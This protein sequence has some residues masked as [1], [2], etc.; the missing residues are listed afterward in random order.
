MT[1][2]F[3]SSPC[4]ETCGYIGDFARRLSTDFIVKVL[5]PPD[6]RAT[7]WPTDVFQLTRSKSA[8][9]FGLDPF[10]AG[11][12]FNQLAS[13]G[14]LS[15][16][17]S[18]PSLLCFL[19]GAFAMGLRADVICSQWMIP[20]GL[21]GALLSRFLGKP[22]IVVEHSGA[23]HF[24]ARSRAGRML[25]RFIT[26]HSDRVVVVSADLRRKLAAICPHAE[27]KIDVVP[28]GITVAAPKGF[29][30]SARLDERHL[31]SKSTIASSDRTILFIG[32]LTEIKG[33]D[34]L[35]IAMK[36]I[37]NV[38]LIV[39]GDGEKRGE[40]ERLARELSIYA[41]FVGQVGA[42]E[43][44]ALLSF[45]DA[46][47]IPS[48][49][50][51]DGRTE[52]TPVVCLEALA[53]GCVLVASRVGGLAD[54]IVDGENGLLFEPGNHRMLR[55]KLMRALEDETLRQTLSENARRTAAAY[56]WSRIGTRFS[57]IIRSSLNTHG[58]P[59]NKRIESGNICG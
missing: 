57:I 52:G 16:L 54:V 4:D 51:A 20:A 3:P 53:A 5:A 18:L 32:R 45:C 15:K 34:L 35:L 14:I 39:A 17:L 6:S 10:Q 27:G 56:D 42:A 58:E 8:V 26:S 59:Y 33:L 55:E 12:D 9:P 30:T 36:D 48:R 7:R 37:T 50:M 19:A 21:I 13:R 47:V 24:L 38:R 1:S 25:A 46:V 44:S 23:L 11:A 29:V 41:T 28:M 40:L 2:S 43:R 31:V 22:H 49:V